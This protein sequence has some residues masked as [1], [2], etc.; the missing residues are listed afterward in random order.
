M[1]QFFYDLFKGV[2]NKAWDLARILSTIGFFSVMILAGFQVY[3]GQAVSL[4]DL[5]SSLMDI[6]IGS[7]LIIAAKDVAGAH[8]KS[9]T[10]TD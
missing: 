5:S 8:A 10:Q 9:L 7:G 4:H 6:L 1:K 2:G 3:T